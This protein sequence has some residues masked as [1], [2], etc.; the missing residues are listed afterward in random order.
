MSDKEADIEVLVDDAPEIEKKVDD[1]EIVTSEEENQAASAETKGQSADEG[2]E[3]LR[4]RLEQ[5][6]LARI[7][8]EKR[9][10][11]AAEQVHKAFAEVEDTQ[12]HLVKSAFDSVRRDQDLLRANLREAMQIGDYDKAA[13]I[14]EA[15]SMNSIKLSQLEQGL[16]E[17]QNRAKAAQERPQQPPQQRNVDDH[18][19]DLIGRVTPLSARWLKE[20]RDHLKDQRSLRIVARAHEDALDMGIIPNPMSIFL[21]LNPVWASGEGKI[22]QKMPLCPLHRPRFSAKRP[23]RRLPCRRGSSSSRPGTVKLTPLQAEAAKISGLT[24]QEYYRQMMREEPHPLKE[25]KP[26]L[27]LQL[28]PPAPA[29]ARRAL[30][31]RRLRLRRLDLPALGAVETGPVADVAPVA[32]ERPAIRPALRE[33]PR[34]AAARRAAEIRNHFQGNMDDGTDRFAAPRPP[35]GWTY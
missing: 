2:I 20:N 29:D 24:A 15:M 3:E 32:A 31:G 34:V 4:R 22:G 1:V 8:A 11:Q 21:L 14:N 25:N 17:M 28:L 19:D 18:V 26:C 35:E 10:S 7:E 16:V 30:V 27:M 9:A 23:L 12:L 6:R 5:E 13:E 33:D